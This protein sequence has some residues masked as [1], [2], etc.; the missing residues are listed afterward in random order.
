MWNVVNTRH[1]CHHLIKN[2]KYPEMSLNETSYAGVKHANHDSYT[3]R[4]VYFLVFFFVLAEKNV[5]FGYI[6]FSGQI[7]CQYY[8]ASSIRNTFSAETL[9]FYCA[10]YEY[11]EHLINWKSAFNLPNRLWS[12]MKG[13]VPFT[14]Q[15]LILLQLI[16]LSETRLI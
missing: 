7:K 13:H 5:Q 16:S 9:S 3:C 8:T 15:H 10:K 12:T 2:L 14:I 1:S 6:R 11:M 4:R